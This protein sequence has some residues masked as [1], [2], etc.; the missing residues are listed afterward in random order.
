MLNVPNHHSFHLISTVILLCLREFQ[1]AWEGHTNQQDWQLSIFPRWFG[2]NPRLEVLKYPNNQIQYQY[3]TNTSPT[4]TISQILTSNNGHL[5]NEKFLSNLP[6]QKHEK[7]LNKSRS[8]SQRVESYIDIQILR[9]LWFTMRY[10]EVPTN[11]PWKPWF[12]FKT[13]QASL[14]NLWFDHQVVDVR[15]CNGFPYLGSM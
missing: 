14:E 3:F 10:V 1:L 7:Q 13:H 5:R 2:I 8:S 4:I 6:L 15:H 12:F 9:L 11:Q